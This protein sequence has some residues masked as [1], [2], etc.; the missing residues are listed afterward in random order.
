M[1]KTYAILLVAIFCEVAGTMLLPVSN[2]FTRVLPTVCLAL[3]Y[4]T[5]FYLM[6]FVMDK[7]PIAIVYATWSGLGVFTIAI[8]GYFFFKQ[9]LA[10]QAVVGLFLIVLGVILVN[11]FAVKLN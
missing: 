5:S 4:L 7:I 11:S 8:L 2:N 10:W 6:T 1:V 9:T 3:F